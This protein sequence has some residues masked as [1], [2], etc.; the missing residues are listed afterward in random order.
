MSQPLMWIGSIVG[1][2]TIAA[3]MLRETV[4][5]RAIAGLSS[6]AAGYLGG[7]LLTAR[8]IPGSGSPPLGMM[9]GILAGG[10]LAAL[11]SLAAAIKLTEEKD[12]SRA[13]ITAAAGAAL[14]LMLR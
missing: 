13:M 6:V 2:A 10:P 4:L 8:L 11:L 7:M 1:L 9:V 5:S 3:W 14:A 12:G